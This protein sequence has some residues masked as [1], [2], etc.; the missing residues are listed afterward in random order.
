MSSLYLGSGVGDSST[1]EASGVAL[2]LLA[3][4]E[5]KI[6]KSFPQDAVGKILTL[7]WGSLVFLLEPFAWISFWVWHLIPHYSSSESQKGG[8]KN[9]THLK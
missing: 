8:Y 4:L 2:F 1:S 5:I 6:Y 3:A 9:Y 7:S